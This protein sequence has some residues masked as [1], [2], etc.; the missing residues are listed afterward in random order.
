ML[1][2]DVSRYRIV[3]D[4]LEAIRVN[5][6]YDAQVAA[7]CAEIGELVSRILHNVHP[8]ELDFGDVTDIY[9]N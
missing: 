5:A 1:T 4:H 6:Q 2:T 7:E 9:D 3:T 8:D